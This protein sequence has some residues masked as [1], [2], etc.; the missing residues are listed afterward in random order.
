I[1]KALNSYKEREGASMQ[2]VNSIGQALFMSFSMFWEILWPLI[3][4]FTLSAIIQAIISRNAMA[5]S[6]GCNIRNVRGRS[7]RLLRDE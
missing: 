5:K 6:P 4:G 2:I 7:A 3:P 1:G